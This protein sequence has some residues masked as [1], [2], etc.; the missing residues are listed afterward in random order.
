MSIDLFTPEDRAVL[1][2]S[3]G[4]EPDDE[5]LVRLLDTGRQLAADAHASA[6][7][8]YPAQLETYR[9]LLTEYERAH[10]S[11][12]VAWQA[13]DRHSRRYDGALQTWLTVANKED[14][15]MP[16]KPVHPG[17][18]P[19]RPEAPAEPS[20]PTDMD[21]VAML[22]AE[23]R[24]AVL[25]ME[26]EEISEASPD[27]EVERAEIVNEA[28]D[29]VMRKLSAQQRESEALPSPVADDAHKFPAPDERPPLDAEAEAALTTDDL[30][31]EP[32]DVASDV[33]SK[34]S[35]D[36]RRR[37][38]ELLN[39]ELAELQLARGGPKEDRRREQKIERLLGIFARAGEM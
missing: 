7:N 22:M 37:F 36:R 30:L 9:R 32:D 1:A 23:Q 18:A 38:T 24:A 33:I 28:Y 13:F 15:P 14:M 8:R 16:A 3:F 17:P 5:L 29:L 2:V 6:L 35:R 12:S 31:G 4:R 19:E 34:L 20:E 25:R 26:T 39:V 21:A 11:W 10:A 27:M